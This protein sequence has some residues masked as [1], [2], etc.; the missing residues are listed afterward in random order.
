M[1][2]DENVTKLLFNRRQATRERIH[3]HTFHSCDLDLDPMTLYEFDL[4]IRKMYQH[5]KKWTFWVTLSEVR[6]IQTDRQT[7]NATTNHYHAALA[8]GNTRNTQQRRAVSLRMRRFLFMIY[9][10]Q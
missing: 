5:A 7:D 4:G 2:S 1:L 10:C 9:F 3:R 8:G 6:A